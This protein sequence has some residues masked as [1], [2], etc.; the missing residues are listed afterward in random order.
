MVTL[1]SK[2]GEGEYI[3]YQKEY[4][5]K[6]PDGNLI[7]LLK[8]NIEETIKFLKE[9]PAER[10]NYRYAEGKWNIPEVVGHLIDTERILTYRVL[11]FARADKT[12]LPPFEEKDY[13]KNSN[14][15]E[16][17]FQNLLDE[18]TALRTSTIFLIESFNDEMLKRSGI[19][20]NNS[21]TVNALC[22]VIAGH[23]LH[24][25]DIIKGRYL[26]AAEAIGVL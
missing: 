2:P 23:E 19:A 26:V 18:Y 24:H 16:R 25:V 7:D 14:V 11:R 6:I 20:N 5:D 22:Y 8:N 13:V 9:I 3:N 17:E 21:V 12:P 1:W 4:I 10:L 15:H